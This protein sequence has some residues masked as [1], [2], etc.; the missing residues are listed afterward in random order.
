MIKTHKIIIFLI[1]FF[2]VTMTY[3]ESDKTANMK[4]FVGKWKNIC[5]ADKSSSKKICVLERA[6]FIDKKLEKRLITMI[7]QTD[8]SSE[9]ILF[10]LVNPLGTLIMS[11]VKIGLNN[12]LIDD[13]PFAFN[14]CDQGGCVTSFLIKKKTFDICYKSNSLDL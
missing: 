5:N 13:K 11:G 4:I 14:Y 7:M 8:S 2:N 12:K 3:A 1:F 10:T 6:M 9:D